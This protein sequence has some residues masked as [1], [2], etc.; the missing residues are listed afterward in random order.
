LR[1]LIGGL[2]GQGRVS[3]AVQPA[4]GSP[5]S[6]LLSAADE[7][8][9]DL[10]VVGSHRR[11]GLARVLG[12]SVAT[13]LARQV[14]RIPVVCVPVPAAGQGAGAKAPP[15]ILTVLAPTD[16]SDTGN[17]AV[18]YAYSLLRATGGVVELCFVNEHPLPTPPYAFD[19]PSALTPAD[20]GAIEKQLRA[21]VPDEAEALGITTHVSVI[22]G[23][24]A[25]EA[26]VAAAERLNV[27]AINIGSHGRGGVA[28]AVLGSVADAV[29]RQARRPVLIVPARAR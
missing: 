18:P 10:L 23:G 4:L 27:D 17:A 9:Y 8:P 24:K 16:L 28:R 19:L 22:D 11:H 25:A 7:R 29:V 6:N 20:R 14:E 13:S 3:L 15:R 1:A 26:I 21:L 5:A 12:G 2:P